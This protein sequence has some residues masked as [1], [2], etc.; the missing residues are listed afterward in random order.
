[1]TFAE[2][3]RQLR[4]EKGLTLDEVGQY[5]GVGKA[6]IYKYEHGI[7]TNIPPD[8]VHKLAN[9]FGVTRP[10]MMGWTD[11]REIN[12]HKN[13]DTVAQNLRHSTG[14]IVTDANV[15]YWQ[16][17]GDNTAD[18][19]TAATQALRALVKFGIART[20]VYPQHIIQHSQYATL[21]TFDD[22]SE[23]DEVVLNSSILT[24][25][26]GNDIFVS[27]MFTNMQGEDHYL[28]IVNRSS[29]IGHLKLAL[30]VELGHIYLGHASLL[31]NKTRKMQEAEC[32]AMHL[33][34]P[35][36]V[37][38]LLSER[39]F[40]FTKKTF[41]RIF[42]DCD[43]CLNSLLNAKA[44]QVSPELNHLVKEQFIPYVNKLEEIGIIDLPVGTD[45]VLDFSNYMAGYED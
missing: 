39:G 29:H 9:L 35:R 22:E 20:P 17:V 2:R 34:F 4:E 32:F 37:I 36:P 43:W 13:L 41:S 6:N 8:K 44:V 25:L 19:T 38:K 42:G 11:E 10:Y 5:I 23:I 28:F 24:S 33:I 31:R 18:C 16:A 1:M 21:I 12:P 40:V 15:R 14:T 45:E 30:G 27:A 26:H 7:V 3:L